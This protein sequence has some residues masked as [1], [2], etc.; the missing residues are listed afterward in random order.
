MPP[1]NPRG[2][3]GKTGGG[4]YPDLLHPTYLPQCGM[5]Q[6]SEKSQSITQ[7]LGIKRNRFDERMEPIDR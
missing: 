2:T 5:S 6:E 7:R 4:H 3:I 1:S